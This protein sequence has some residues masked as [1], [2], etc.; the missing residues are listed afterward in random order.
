YFLFLTFALIAFENV[1]SQIARYGH[2]ANLINQ[3][4]YII[5]GKD[6]TGAF[7]NE[8][9]ILDL[10]SNFSLVNISNN[11]INITSLNFSVAWGTSV[12][13]GSS[14][15]YFGGVTS[16]NKATAN[17][18]Q[19]DTNQNLLSKPLEVSA[20]PSARRG[21][22]SVIDQ[23]GT[24]YIYGGSGSI[25]DNPYHLTSNNDPAIY[26]LT[27]TTKKF[28]E[29]ASIQSTNTKTRFDY[30]ATV[31]GN[32][33]IYIGG[34]TTNGFIGMEEIWIFQT[35]TMQWRIS[36]A[37]N[38]GLVPN[39][40]G[41][42]AVKLNN[43]ILI[44]GGYS[45]QN[46]N[47][48]NNNNAVALLSIQNLGARN[49]ETFTWKLPTISSSPYQNQQQIPYWHTATIYNNYMIVVYG[50]FDNND[51]TNTSLNVT[52]N[53]STI[54][55]N[56][57]SKRFP[58]TP[59]TSQSTLG[60]SQP[61]QGASQPTASQQEPVVSPPTSQSTQGA[62]QQ[63]PVVSPPTSQSTQGASQQAPVVPPPAPVVSPPVPVISQKA[64]VAILDVSNETSMTWVQTITSTQESDG[65]NHGKK[66]NAGK[67]K[68]L[69]DGQI[70]DSIQSTQNLAEMVQESNSNNPEMVQHSN[71]INRFVQ[72]HHLPEKIMSK[73]NNQIIQQP[74]ARNNK[75][76]F[77]V[78]FHS[79]IRISKKE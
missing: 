50:K 25:D 64:P 12:D 56:K 10:S 63:A 53:D 60:T 32:N 58:E 26:S 52:N 74:T 66:N 73:S 19:Y 21:L 4:I 24:W 35:D 44:Y 9:Q 22:N 23:N 48:I 46:S 34:Q 37:T 75:F 42:T 77:H 78:S 29:Q 38:A 11:F 68:E 6:A 14:I 36:N 43:S 61:A 41:H 20:S 47:P 59:P 69:K 28:T 79:P 31:I 39:R 76:N 15:F 70:Q 13:N 71:N 18:I 27:L 62:S 5:G 16:D 57:K 40:G 67:Q 30:T 45:D 72:S 51:N 2:T 49:G 8:M 55:S 7:V 3:K 65:P 17:I 33:I 1:N 54:L